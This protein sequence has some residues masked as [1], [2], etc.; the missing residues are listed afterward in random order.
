MADEETKPTTNGAPEGEATKA[1]APA[2][3]FGAASTFG[4]G[5]G[6]GGFTGVV[7]KAEGKEAEGE[8]DGDDAAPE[9]ECA[10]EF[11]P[12]VQL[13]EV[14]VS[15]G[16]EEEENLFD[17]KSKLYRFDNE[18]SEWKERGV[19]QAKLLKHK[20]SSRIRFLMRQDKTLKIRANHV[21]MPGTK[22]QEHTGSEKAM[23]FS[24]VDFADEVQRPELFCIRFAS[25]ERAQD[26]QKAYEEA[27]AANESVL[28][29]AAPADDEGSGSESD[30]EATSIS[31]Q[32]SDADKAAEELATKAKV[33]EEAAP[34]KEESA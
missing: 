12:V 28:G 14:E 22:V 24:C 6:F 13:D 17:Y 27:A 34:A 33:E 5:T 29:L 23:V 10:A 9:E 26:F 20:E 15:T 16:E 4:A 7:A 32:K 3:I 25:A 18:S 11:K 21:V 30:E 31:P 8:D 19:G 1:P 2:P